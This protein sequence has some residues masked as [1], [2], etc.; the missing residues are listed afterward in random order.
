MAEGGIR[1]GRGSPKN[2]TAGYRWADLPRD[3]LAALGRA[4]AAGIEGYQT[5]L[6]GHDEEGRRV[7][8]VLPLAY[9]EAEDTY[10]PAFPRILDLWNTAGGFAPATGG[11]MLGAGPVSRASSMRVGY[12]PK[13]LDQRPFHD[14]YAKG[15][16]GAEGSPLRTSIDGGELIAPFVAGRRHVG[17]ADVGLGAGEA[18]EVAERLVDS[19]RAVPSRELPIRGGRRAVGSFHAERGP[20]RTERLIRYDKGLGADD[21]AI[22]IAHELGHAIDNLAGEI[23][24]KPGMRQQLEQVFHDLATGWQGRKR[25]K[26]LPE[27]LGYPKGRKADLE[28]IAEAI[29]AY[30]VDPNYLKTVAPNAA[31][32]IRKAVNHNPRINHT[33]Q[34][35]VQSPTPTGGIAIGGG[36]PDR[37]RLT[38]RDLE[39]MA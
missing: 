37:R 7:G 4:G 14:D 16:E 22:T 31:K 18:V 23:D 38:L 21:A 36:P 1:I 28:L 15:I 19:V 20:E 11:I 39:D 12:N 6:S 8:A 35:N 33:L 34:F 25:H 13:P 3:I 30:M 32:A 17:G 29:R 27:S 10:S 2:D 26:T 5:A 9:D 24:I